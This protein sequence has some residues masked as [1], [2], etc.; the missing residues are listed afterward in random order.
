M[1][2]RVFDQEVVSRET[3]DALCEH[4]LDCLR[5]ISFFIKAGNALKEERMALEVIAE[6]L[7]QQENELQEI[8]QQA[9]SRRTKTWDGE[10]QSTA[11]NR[12][13]KLDSESI[14]QEDR[15]VFGKLREICLN[16]GDEW[17]NLKAFT[18]AT[19]TILRKRLR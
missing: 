7:K 17:E 3:F 5:K 10:A 13:S 19:Y 9:S 8:R 2:A 11:S 14:R 15:T 18:E 16:G 12:D 4:G 6:F 1:T